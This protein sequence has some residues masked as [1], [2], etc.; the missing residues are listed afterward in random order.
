MILSLQ[1]GPTQLQVCM[2][3][4]ALQK[5]QQF[6]GR[7][8]FSQEVKMAM[9]S[10]GM[11]LQGQWWVIGLRSTSDTLFSKWILEAWAPSFRHTYYTSLLT[12]WNSF[13]HAPFNPF[14][15][16]D[17]LGGSIYVLCMH[18]SFTLKVKSHGPFKPFHPSRD[19]TKKNGWHH[20]FLHN[21]PPCRA[22]HFTHSSCPYV[23]FN[24]VEASP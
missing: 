20:P 4:G 24:V 15:L 16:V 22:T 1:V 10:S 3:Q 6:Q 12:F 18:C 13:L 2:I 19:V 14:I 7:H 8:C 21:A 17:V 23:S 5:Q 11:L 9:L